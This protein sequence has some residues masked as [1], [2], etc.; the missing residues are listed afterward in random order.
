M[1]ERNASSNWDFPFARAR[2]ISRV[3]HSATTPASGA[4]QSPFAR[5]QAMLLRRHHIHRQGLG[6][7]REPQS[8]GYKDGIG[9]PDRSS[10][11]DGAAPARAD[12]SRLASSFWISG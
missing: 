12:P 4:A 1:L 9:Q 7:S 11:V 8:F 3:T 5:K 10:G 6:R 2:S